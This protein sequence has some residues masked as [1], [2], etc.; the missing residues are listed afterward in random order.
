[1][2]RQ[3]TNTVIDFGTREYD[4][5]RMVR[6]ARKIY[7]ILLALQLFRMLALLAVVDL[8][9]FVVACYNGKLTRVV[10]VEGCYRDGARSRSFEALDALS[11]W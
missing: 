4:A 3:V 2:R 6:E 8:D 7:T 10:E 11:I 1:M 5:L 9:R